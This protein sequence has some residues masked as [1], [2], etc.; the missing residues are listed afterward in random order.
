[1]VWFLLIVSLACWLMAF[2]VHLGV[3]MPFA[4]EDFGTRTFLVGAATFILLLLVKVPQWQVA[5]LPDSVSDRFDKENEARKTFAQVVAGIGL[6]AG[7]YFTSLQVREVQ[8]ATT[9][10]QEMARRNAEQV[11]DGQ[12]TDRYIKAVEQLGSTDA[13]RMSVRIGA[14]FALERIARESKTDHWPIM[15]LLTAFVRDR[16]GG[17]EKIT[18]RPDN[19]VDR[20]RLRT[21]RDHSFIAEAV[22][23]GSGRQYLVLR[24]SDGTLLNH[25]QNQPPTE[26]LQ[27]AMTVI[28]RRNLAYES[29][30]SLRLNLRYANLRELNLESAHLEGADLNDVNLYGTQLD[31]A[32]L[33]GASLRGVYFVGASL[34]GADLRRAVISGVMTTA[35]PMPNADLREAVMQNIDTDVPSVDGKTNLRLDDADTRGLIVDNHILPPRGAHLGQIRKD[36]PFPPARP[37]SPCKDVSSDLWNSR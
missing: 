4:I 36:L 12:I 21:L 22:D 30:Q 20:Q 32:C 28:G 7:L 6:V 34:A 26:D 29:D 23:R 31:L 15:E 14:I 5:S 35:A 13:E 9:N 11:R 37:G 10:S 19:L 2:L 27:A 17:R 25:W 3:N 8:R 33:T 18:V 16:S 1:V 24:M